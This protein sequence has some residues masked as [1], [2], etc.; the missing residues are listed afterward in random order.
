VLAVFGWDRAWVAGR[1]KRRRS[2]ASCPACGGLEEDAT[3]FVFT[4]V[5]QAVRD[6]MYSRL[7]SITSGALGQ[8]MFD[9]PLDTMLLG[10]LGDNY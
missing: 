8:L 7:D 10:M 3:H 4:Y 9:K 1:R 5:V 6:H 2:A